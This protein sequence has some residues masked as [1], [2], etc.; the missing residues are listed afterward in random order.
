MI[1]C[2]FH[3]VLCQSLQSKSLT[4]NYEICANSLPLKKRL[5]SDILFHSHKF[6]IAHKRHY[7][8]F[9]NILMYQICV[10]A[11]LSHSEEY[12]LTGM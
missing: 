9:S 5:S 12:G 7:D 1:M 8:I 6:M 11:T 4:L 3:F 2:K 10:V